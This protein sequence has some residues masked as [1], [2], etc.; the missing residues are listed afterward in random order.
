M[1][2]PGAHPCIIRFGP[3]EVDSFNLE[4]RKRGSIVKLP[5]QQFALLLMLTERAG[6][7]V[8]RDEIHQRIWGPDTFVDFER[9]INFSINQIRAALGDNAENP[10]YIETIPR[11]GYRFIARIENVEP[12]KEASSVLDESISTNH[13][14]NASGS[15]K[16]VSSYSD[17]VDPPTPVDA[18]RVLSRKK[19]LIG[20]L[21]LVTAIGLSLV[22][23]RM[24]HVGAPSANKNATARIRT[25]PLTT[26]NG[27]IRDIELSPDGRQIAFVWNGPNLGRF[28]IYVQLI[29]GDR[30]LQITHSQ[31]RMVSQINWSP[32]GRLLALGRCGDENRGALYTISPLGDPNKN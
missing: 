26:F 18:A 31:D 6:Q 19:L 9:G 25:F 1:A 30:P 29:G 3:F 22:F 21:A 16:Q 8:S 23:S 12:P 7:I 20:C 11:R 5:R 14:A 27:I 28:E 2:S 24:W 15:E 13:S 32:D 17:H 4:L 10:S